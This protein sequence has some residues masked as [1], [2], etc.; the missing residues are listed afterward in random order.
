MKKTILFITFSFLLFFSSYPITVVMNDQEIINSVPL[1]TGTK[2]CKDDA[3]NIY[4]L[5]N[6]RLLYYVDLSSYSYTNPLSPCS[7]TCISTAVSGTYV[8]AADN[9]DLVYEN[10][11]VYFISRVVVNS[12]TT[13]KVANYYKTGM[14]WY[15]G[16]LNSSAQDGSGAISLDEY[17]RLFYAGTNGLIYQLS[18]MNGWTTSALPLPGT[19]ISLTSDLLARNNHIFYVGTDHQLYNFYRWGNDWWVGIL[20][21]AGQTAADFTAIEEDEAGRIHY[22]GSDGKIH[23]Y[24]YSSGWTEEPINST[25]TVFASSSPKVQKYCGKM[26]Y[27]D[28]A[29]HTISFAFYTQE[30]GWTANTIYANNDYT[31]TAHS[32]SNRSDILITDNGEVV[33]NSTATTNPLHI[34][35]P[36]INWKLATIATGIPAV[37]WISGYD[38][39]ETSLCRPLWPQNEQF[40]PR[41]SSDTG[42]V[43]CEGNI[44]GYYD[45]TYSIDRY[46][47]PPATPADVISPTNYTVTSPTSINTT[48]GDFFSFPALHAELSEYT[49][50]YRLNGQTRYTKLAEKLVCGDA[51]IAGGQSNIQSLSMSPAEL[52]SVNYSYGPGS[53]N[54]YG[55]YS[56]TFG[57]TFFFTKNNWGVSRAAGAWDY[58][59]VE[60]ALMLPVMKMIE[61]NYQVP[62]CVINNAIGLTKIESHLL[63]TVYPFYFGLHND[64]ADNQHIEALLLRRVYKAGLENNI[65]GFIWY[66]GESDAIPGYTSGDYKTKFKKLYDGLA[67]AIPSMSGSASPNPGFKTYLLQIHSMSSL[68]TSVPAVNLLS[69]DLRTISSPDFSYANITVIASNGARYPNCTEGIHF[70]RKG[71]VDIAKRIYNAMKMGSYGEAYNVANLSPNIVSA[72]KD[73]STGA[74]FLHFNQTLDADLT[75]ED[76]VLNAIYLNN[77][78]DKFNG[79]ISGNTFSFM[80]S[81]AAGLTSVSYLG[82]MPPAYSNEATPDCAGVP[83]SQTG[84]WSGCHI[85]N[86]NENA[87]FSF[88]NFPLTSV[89]LPA[90]RVVKTGFTGD[91]NEQGIVVYPNPAGNLL[92]ITANAGVLVSV[93]VYDNAGRLVLEMKGS[94]EGA[95]DITDLSS[96]IYSLIVKT[97]AQTFFRKLIKL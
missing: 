9:T 21:S 82:S 59:P 77:S 28:T 83:N 94:S 81:S 88:Y 80:V 25:A 97:T 12:A 30:S 64:P 72:E 31:P 96:G 70:T 89:A 52:D 63:D 49:I 71:Y 91:E 53:N 46:A 7:A 85:R 34:L 18:W 69:E 20:G 22:V 32:H 27:A 5:G 65:K 44:R 47:G 19:A 60:G 61:Q 50:Y 48:T 37:Y 11:H 14:T 40:Y 79:V 36:H 45:I 2:M 8:D 58:L 90:G 54:S 73:P 4:F 74:V 93:T 13:Y 15:C 39:S 6:D 38:S 23:Q 57:H 1:L 86:N 43:T 66:Q 62:V 95:M 68:F 3:G 29:A 35:S 41:N 17:G 56:R 51:Y 10:D 78:A 76:S 87:A 75:N 26:Y 33:Y 24:T 55:R 84:W 67:A 16:V 42:F 92:N